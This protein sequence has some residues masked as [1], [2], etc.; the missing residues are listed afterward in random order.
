MNPHNVIPVAALFLVLLLIIIR[1]IGSFRLPMWAIMLCGA[2][3]VI[4]TGSISLKEAFSAIN[5]D[6]LLFLAGMFITARAFEESGLLE[7]L[8]DIIHGV[9]GRFPVFIVLF[10]FVMA[11]LSAILMNDTLAVIGT[12]IAV[13]FSKRFK[14]KSTVLLLALAYSVTIGSVFSPIGNPQNLL[15]AEQG[16]LREPFTAF[17]SGLWLPTLINMVL[18]LGLLAVFYPRAFFSSGTGLGLNRQEKKSDPFLKKLLIASFILIML[19]IVVRIILVISGSSIIIP[20]W[21]VAAAGALPVILFYPGRLRIIRTMDYQ[22][23][24][25]FAAM[26]VL[27]QAVWNSGI[28]QAIIPALHI[29]LDNTAGILAGSAGLSQLISNVPFV[30][31]ALPLIPEGSPGLLLALAA[32]STVAGNFMLLGAAS[33]I[34][35]IQNAEKHGET[36]S[37]WRFSLTGIPL[38]LINLGV[39]WIFL[40]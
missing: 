2:L 16:G 6:I 3:C 9:S 32:G 30:L 28:V 11:L 18:M 33:N 13:Y 38:T 39:Y 8:S 1:R 36:V 10:S 35:I 14:V 22:T 20:L 15:I 26:F 40:R 25:F 4:I 27:M 37:F 12:P 5:Y 7:S 23:L 31:L 34:I 24:V 21:A 17:L 19:F 29:R